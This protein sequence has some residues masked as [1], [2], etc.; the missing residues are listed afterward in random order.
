MHGNITATGGA[1][2]TV[3]GFAWGTSPTMEGDTATT[4]D[5]AGQPFG[6]GAFT[7]S[8]QT[9]VCNTT[10]YSRAYATNSAGTGFGAIS[11]SFTTSACATVSISLDQTSF[12]YGRVESNTASSTLPLWGGVGITAT[13]GTA[14][15]DFDI[16]GANSTG[17]GGGWTLSTANN[18]GNNYMHRFCNDTDN[19]CVSPPTNYTA[20]ST[21]PVSLK[22]G[23]ASSG[24]VSFQLQITTPT[25]PT[26][27]SQQSAEVT[28]QA[29]AP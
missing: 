22:A 18:T 9:F 15:A 29:S 28:V 5:T 20:F 27:L 4:S 11:A 1:D 25:T 12:D 26:D 21:T 17:A 13:N 7:D 2:A 19:D 24:A 8:S 14:I 6:T 10:Y 16:Y 3:R 23:V